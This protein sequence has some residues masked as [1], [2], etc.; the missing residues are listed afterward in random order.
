MNFRVWGMGVMLCWCVGVWTPAL[1]LTTADIGTHT[2]RALPDCLRYRVKGLCF[3]LVTQYGAPRVES[4]LQMQHYLPDA[5]VTVFSQADTNPWVFARNTFDKLAY[6]MGD[7]VIRLLMKQRM[8]HG[9]HG[10]SVPGNQVSFKEVDVIGHPLAPSLTSTLPMIVHRAQV[11]AFYPYFISM[12][13]AFAWRSGIEALAPHS[14]HPSGYTLGP[15]THAWGTIYPREGFVVA[16]DDRLAGSVAAF[17][18][19]HVATNPGIHVARALPQTCGVQCRVAGVI[20]QHSRILWQ[21]LYPRA[22]HRCEAFGQTFSLGDGQSNRDDG[23]HAWV[24]W[25]LYEGCAPHPS[26]QFLAKT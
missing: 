11:T 26:G 14:W 13:D 2:L 6:P 23:R 8:G 24:L 17:R 15:V 10:L 12:Q 22:S 4:T 9:V 20:D 16:A 7:A 3:W 18:A 19:A 1:A 5:V 25:R 21:A